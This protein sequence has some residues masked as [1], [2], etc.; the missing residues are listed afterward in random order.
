M[1]VGQIWQVFSLWRYHNLS[2]CTGSDLGLLNSP[3][4][5]NSTY[6]AKQRK[7]LQCGKGRVSLL[8]P[9]KAIIVWI[10]RVKFCKSFRGRVNTLMCVIKWRNKL[11]QALRMMPTLLGFVDEWMVGL[12]LSWKTEEEK[13]LWFVCIRNC[14]EVGSEFSLL[15]IPLPFKC[16][17]TFW[18]ILL[19]KLL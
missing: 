19:S 1:G 11:K 14:V 17:S 4:T 8:T 2:F 5:V 15:H 16:F 18:I 12:S 9:S 10:K 6:F 3:F 13:Q 7:E